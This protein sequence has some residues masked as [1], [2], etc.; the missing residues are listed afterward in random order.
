MDILHLIQGLREDNL[1]VPKSGRLAEMAAVSFKKLRRMETIKTQITLVFL[2]IVLVACAPNIA[3][4]PTATA[5]AT[6][7]IFSPT[8]T[9]VGILFTPPPTQPA[10][11]L[12]TPDATQ[13]ERWREYQTELAKALFSFSLP[14]QP[15]RRYN[16]EEYKDALCEWDI[17]GQSGQ[18]VYV[19]AACVAAKYFTYPAMGFGVVGVEM[20]P[21]VID[22]EMDGSIR[23]V[24]V[25]GV[26]YDDSNQLPI[27]DLHLFPLDV[28]EKLCLHYFSGLVLNVLP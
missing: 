2:T 26:E 28:Q 3:S 12:L 18:E 16:P 14:Y 27:Y 5:T 9:V 11:P 17:L 15:E 20:N 23:E 21:A 6:P 7:P 8:A 22:L 4:V 1:P 19:W 13:V 10:L 24:N 25:P